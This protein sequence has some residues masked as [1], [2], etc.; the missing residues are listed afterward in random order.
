MPPRVRQT[1][2]GGCHSK[3]PGWGLC[4]ILEWGKGE[5]TREGICVYTYLQPIPVVAQQKLTQHRKV[6][7]LQLKKKV[8]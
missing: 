5:A 7:I 8:V 1:A 4:D 2:V 6:V 3:E